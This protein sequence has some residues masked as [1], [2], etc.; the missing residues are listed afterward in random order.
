MTDAKIIADSIGPSGARITTLQVKLHRMVLAE[1]DTHRAFSR[2]FSSSR[3]IPTKILLNQVQTAPA[4]P[5]YWGKNQAGMQAK[6]EFVGEDRERMIDW[7]KM[8]AS[9]ASLGAE[10]GAAMGVHKQIVNRTIEPYMWVEGIVTSTEWENF[11][12]L[13]CHPDAQPEF[14]ALAYKIREARAL[15]TPKELNYGDWHLP[16]IT[17]ADWYDMESSLG[18]NQYNITTELAKV[19]AA[20]CCR[21]SYLKHDG[22]DPRVEDDIDL[23]FKLAGGVPIHASPLEHQAVCDAGDLR[24]RNFLGWRQFRAIWEEGGSK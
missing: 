6:E 1:L 24:S 10:W 23:F 17:S 8:M 9:V 2:N 3:A 4:M 22:T 15:S 21:V 13:R 19:S 14:Q 11:Y 5:V 18:V 20:R 7:W 12:A 16:Y